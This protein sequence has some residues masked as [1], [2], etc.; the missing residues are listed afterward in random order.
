MENEKT[1]TIKVVSLQKELFFQAEGLDIYLDSIDTSIFALDSKIFIYRKGKLIGTGGIGVHGTHASYQYFYWEGKI[2]SNRKYCR[3]REITPYNLLEGD[4][5]R[6]EEK[7]FK[8]LVSLVK[9]WLDSKLFWQ[10]MHKKYKN[11]STLE[12]YKFCFKK[13]NRIIEKKEK[14]NVV[15]PEIKILRGAK[16]KN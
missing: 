3:M 16:S 4:E 2:F 14:L 12:F 7:K 1:G 13:W 5:I 11:L 8:F 15:Y 6:I 10:K 9:S